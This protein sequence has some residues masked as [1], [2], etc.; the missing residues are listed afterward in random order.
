VIQTPPQMRLRPEEGE[1]RHREART[2]MV[3]RARRPEPAGG[4]GRRRRTALD[5]PRARS[6]AGLRVLVAN[7]TGAG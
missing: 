2:S 5:L 1:R 6:I 3:A 4:V 7:L